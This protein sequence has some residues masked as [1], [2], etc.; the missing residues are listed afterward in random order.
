MDFPTRTE[1]KRKK[2]KNLKKCVEF[3]K[4]RGFL[5]ANNASKHCKKKETL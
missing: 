2:R 5:F 1:N 4:V 3:K